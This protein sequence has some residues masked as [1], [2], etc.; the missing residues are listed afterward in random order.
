MSERIKKTL[1]VAALTL[2]VARQLFTPKSK[3]E[4]QEALATRDETKPA[5]QKQSPPSIPTSKQRR[6]TKARPTGKQARR[7]RRQRRRRK[8]RL[9]AAFLVATLG[10]TGSL[11]TLYVFFL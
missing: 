4:A 9:V 7:Q 6:R 3:T 5:E 2:S 11:A 1:A 8:R 10:M